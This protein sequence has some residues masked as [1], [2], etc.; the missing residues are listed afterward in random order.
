MKKYNLIISSKNLNSLNTFVIFLNK[1]FRLNFSCY[2]KQFIKK[3]KKKVFTILKS[4]HVNKKA[5]EQFGIQFFSIQLT[6]YIN[7]KVR[8][9]IFLKKV[10]MY[11]FPNINIKYEKHIFVN[12]NKLL[13]L[14]KIF[15][16]KNFI[17]LRYKE[18]DKNLMYLKKLK[19][20]IYIY[21]NKN[22]HL[23]KIFDLY[24]NMK[25][26][27]NNPVWIAQLVEQRTEN[28]CDGSSNLPLNK[29]NEKSF[30]EYVYKH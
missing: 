11:L 19:K 25:K 14:S 7:K 4:P 17:T 23:I 27:E 30:M 12:K 10:K 9:L 22:K 13:L 24:G 1:I 8:F 15:N 20:K 5:Q 6:L 26:Y 28:P 16:I 21:E 3:N 18:I 2:N 29:K